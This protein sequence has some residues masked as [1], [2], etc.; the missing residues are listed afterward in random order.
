MDRFPS[1]AGISAARNKLGTGKSGSDTECPGKLWKA[2]AEDRATQNL[3][4]NIVVDMWRKG[5]YNQPRPLQRREH[6]GFP[7]R[8][9]AELENQL[10]AGK[11]QDIRHGHVSGVRGVRTHGHG[12]VSEGMRVHHGRSAQCMV[13]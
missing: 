4:G 1:A 12:R 10:A 13:M 11:P 9:A 6:A 8:E 2:A 3:V 7:S 5:G